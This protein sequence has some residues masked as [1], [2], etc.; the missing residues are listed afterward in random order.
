[1]RIGVS[2]SE[3]ADLHRLG[4]VE[5]HLRLALGEVARVVIRAGAVAWYTAAIWIRT[6]TRPFW[7]PRWTGMGIPTDRSSSSSAGLSIVAFHSLTFAVT[8]TTWA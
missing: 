6:A 3:S 7:S 8:G 5:R 4:L 1:M 2:V